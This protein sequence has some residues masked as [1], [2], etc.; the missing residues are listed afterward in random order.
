M[1]LSSIPKKVKLH[2]IA[3][4]PTTQKRN[5]FACQLTKRVFIFQLAIVFLECLLQRYIPSLEDSFYSQDNFIQIEEVWR[6]KTHTQLTDQ[7]DDCRRRRHPSHSHEP[8]GW[9]HW[10]KDRM[11]LAPL[12]ISSFFQ[13]AFAFLFSADLPNSH[14]HL[15]IPN[16]GFLN[17]QN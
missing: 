3:K 8:L 14:L 5:V 1:A 15:M 2:R 17:T 9:V 11:I 7:D 6:G 16:C 4:P 10:R 13:K 12:S